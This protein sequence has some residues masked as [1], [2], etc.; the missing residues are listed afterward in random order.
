MFM[1]V[2]VELPKGYQ[3]EVTT[4]LDT[5]VDGFVKVEKENAF[6]F[7]SPSKNLTSTKKPF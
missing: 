3:Y 6:K 1:V 5:L 4:R 2:D 7:K